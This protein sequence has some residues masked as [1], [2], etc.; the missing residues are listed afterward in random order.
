MCDDSNS[1]TLI[2]EQSMIIM[3]VLLR[4]MNTWQKYHNRGAVVDWIAF[5]ISFGNITMERYIQFGA[6]DPQTE[7][8]KGAITHL[9]LIKPASSRIDQIVRYVDNSN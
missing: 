1:V 3:T 6:I 5:P 8:L 9:Q 4:Y 2:H 7:P